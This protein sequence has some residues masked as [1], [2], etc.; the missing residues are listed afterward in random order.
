M[1]RFVCEQN[2]QHFQKLLL[3]ARDMTLRRTLLTLLSSAKRELALLNSQLSGADLSP[4]AAY[5]KINGNLATVLAELRPG[6]EISAHP[7]MLIDPRPGLKIID[8]ND[9]Y[10]RADFHRPQR[11]CRQASVRGVSR[12][13]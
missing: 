8:V 4:A 11:H 3:D 10:A 13:S 12:Q 7:Y 5:R 6:F 9:A 1:Q 2:I